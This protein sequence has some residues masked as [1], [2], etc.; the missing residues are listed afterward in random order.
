MLRV[1]VYEVDEHGEEK[2]YLDK[3]GN[4][5]VNEGKGLVMVTQ[6]AEIVDGGIKA[7]GNM[8]ILG[9]INP[10]AMGTLLNGDENI[11][12]WMAKAKLHKVMK[13]IMCE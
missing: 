9:E 11:N 6:T 7:G 4:P 3:E 12:K 5:V 8:C 1:K 10:L 2:L 13:E